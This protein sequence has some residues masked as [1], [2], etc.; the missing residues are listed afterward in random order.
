MAVTL[1]DYKVTERWGIVVEGAVGQNEGVMQN[2]QDLLQASKLPGVKWG[3]IDAQPSMLKG[4]FGNKRSYLMVTNEALK[5]WCMYVSARDYG[6]HMDVSWFLTV[7]PGFFKSMFSAMLSHGNI[8]ALS[9]SLDLFSQQDLRAYVTSVHSLAVRKAV[10]AVS[11]ELGQDSSRF[12]WRS[13]GF[14]E[15]W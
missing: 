3:K 9:Y 6:A 7:E 11:S 2:I 8:K 1:N 12:D 5:D 14:L 4:L 15:V 13:K 10:E